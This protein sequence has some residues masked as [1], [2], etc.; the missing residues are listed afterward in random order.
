[1][2][3]LSHGHQGYKTTAFD[4]GCTIERAPSLSFCHT[5]TVAAFCLSLNTFAPW[6]LFQCFSEINNGVFAI[7]HKAFSEATLEAHEL[8]TASIDCKQF[9]TENATS[10]VIA[11]FFS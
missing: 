11:L 10:C 3:C 5:C 8:S 7:K 6:P 2:S 4:F 1:M 9:A